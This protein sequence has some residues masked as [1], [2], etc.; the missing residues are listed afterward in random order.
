MTGS[1]KEPFSSGDYRVSALLS[2]EESCANYTFT[3][4]PSPWEE[5][6]ASTR[7]GFIPIGFTRNNL[8]INYLPPLKIRK[9]YKVVWLSLALLIVFLI[10]FYAVHLIGIKMNYVLI[11]PDGSSRNVVIH[12][13]GWKKSN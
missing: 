11:N 9:S 12:W 2:K 8:R 13:G 10:S 6:I 3:D 1:N 4:K 5:K 7:K